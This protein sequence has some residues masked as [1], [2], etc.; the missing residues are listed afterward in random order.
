MTFIEVLEDHSGTSTDVD[1]IDA[2]LD[3]PITVR[4]V[5][6]LSG[7]LQGT[8]RALYENQR[9][10][11]TITMRKVDARNVGRLIA[12]FERA[13]GFYAS[14]VNINAY[15][16]PG[17]E[18]GKKAATAVL[19]LQTRALALLEKHKGGSYTAD[20]LAAALE[21]EETEEDIFGIARQFLIGEQEDE[22]KR[23]EKEAELRKK[24][25]EG[26]FKPDPETLFKILRHLAANGRV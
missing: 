26:A 20:R 24:I 17:V 4:S 11:M 9:E 15:H 10:S 13:V 12:L 5:D 14:L 25:R 19:I 1:I 18:A 8:R 3:Q 16:Q 7:F 6:Y 2:G 23:K 21:A 22:E